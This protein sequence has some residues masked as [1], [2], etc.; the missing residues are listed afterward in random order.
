[1]NHKKTK[2]ALVIAVAA[3]SFPTAVVA[4]EGVST[5]LEEIVVSARKRSES[6]QDVGLAVSAL[7][8]VEI[9]RTFAR[10]LSDLA[11]VSPN[12][13]ID[14]TAQGPGGVAAIFIRGI[15][16]ADVEKSFDPAVGVVVDGIFLGANAGSLLRSI[17]L[18]SVEVLRG[19]QGTLFG[20]NTIG[21]LINITHTQPTGE[22]GAR[23]RAGAED[24]DTYY[25]DGIFNFGITDDLGAKITLGKRDQQEGYY[26]NVTVPGDGE[27]ENDYQTYGLNM[28]WNAS[29][30]LEFEASYQKEE[31]DQ[32]TPPLLNTGQPGRHLFCDVYGYCSPSLTKPITGDRLKV[33]NQGF[34]PA[35]A[36]ADKN[37]PFKVTSADDLVPKKLDAT[38]D[39]ESWSFETRWNLSDSYRI[40]YLYGHW[41]SEETI[42]SNWDGTPE[43]LYGT[44][45][46]ADYDQD[47]HELRLTYD[48]NEKLSFVAGAYYWESQ[49]EMDLNSHIG[50]AEPGLVYDIYQHTKMTTDSWAVFFEGDYELT[51]A[52]TF[53]LGG[54][55]TEDEKESRQN[56]AQG[57]NIDP[58]TGQYPKEDWDEFTPRIGAR[59]QFTEDLMAFATYSKGYR[60]GGFLG[61]VDSDES[62]STPYDPETVDNYELGIKSEWWDNRLRVNANVFYMEYDDKQEELQLP[63]N[64]ATGQKTVVSN[65][66]SATIEGV[67]L[68][69]QASLSE[70]LSLRANIGYL[71]TSYDDF[72]YE[73]L[74][75]SIV[76]LSDVEFR[77][78]PDWTGSLDATYEWDMAGGT[79]WVRGAYH[80][81]G[82]H[83]VSVDNSPELK[84]DDQHLIDAS[85]NYSINAFTFSIYGRNL[86]DE[87]GYTHG[88]DVDTLWS[89]AATRPPRTYGLEVIYN[90]GE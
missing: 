51:D 3:T 82:E 22:L 4:L 23:V 7:S 74:D 66:S 26:D 31:T 45:R 9:E 56:G 75:G 85:V 40:D 50:F 29:D 81:I 68:E 15:G 25:V 67:E 76:D 21:G 54:R 80:F 12:L 70:N 27:G 79:A 63:S 87:D 11:S 6:L 58:Q 46:P 73:A 62:A 55:Y 16:V 41:E 47:S 20:R 84:N 71:D 36:P 52:L 28:L 38:F 1:M 24:Y 72:N 69:V 59:Y 49:Y 43:L 10:D 2:L 83:F 53:T 13:I 77:R 65:A 61:R 33:A 5:T 48:S 42:L 39:T 60:S 8:R 57:N 89:Y 88:Y 18:A 14:D 30:K 86:T 78:A 37:N 90:F 64:D 34:L 35:G 17:D 32:D 19:P 44:T